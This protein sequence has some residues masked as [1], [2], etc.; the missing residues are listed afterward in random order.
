MG[1][2]LIL[3]VTAI[4]LGL[5]GNTISPRGIPLKTPA[6]RSVEEAELISLPQATELWE[7]GIAVFLDARQPEDFVAG[8]IAN[9]FNL[10]A[11]SFEAHFDE[12]ASMLTPESRIVIYCDGTECEFSHLLKER[13]GEMGF[14]SVH[15][16]F[17]GWTVWREAGLPTEQ[18][19]AN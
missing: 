18:G 3:L 4:A 9:A 10:P 1:R 16:L 12:I 11:T 15:I 17:N 2:A 6:A 8:H 14:T 7:N 5:V 13:L 19:G